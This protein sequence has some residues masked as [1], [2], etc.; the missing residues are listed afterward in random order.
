MLQGICNGD[1]DDAAALVR[2]KAT[3]VAQIQCH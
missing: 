1:D 3:A 2:P